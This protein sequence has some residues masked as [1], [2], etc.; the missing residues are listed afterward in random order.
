MYPTRLPTTILLVF[1]AT[2]FFACNNQSKE[3][4]VP[5]TPEQSK[6]VTNNANSSDT[7]NALMANLEQ[8]A[9]TFQV[10]GTKPSVVKGKKG[11][12]IQINPDDL[13][14]KDG[15]APTGEINVTL[16]ELCNQ[17]ELALNNAPTI[18]NGNLLVSGGA[19]YIGLYAN[20]EELR[21]KDGR[22]L[23][24]SF[25]KLSNQKMTLFY[26]ERNSKGELNW[27]DSKKTLMPPKVVADL[28]QLPAEPYEG[29][30][31]GNSNT[32]VNTT[33]KSGKDE[34]DAILDYVD[35]T[36]D[37]DL[38]PINKLSPEAREKYEQYEKTRKIF[39]GT[40]ETINVQQLGWINVDYFL[41]EKNI[42]ELYVQTTSNIK[43]ASI[44]CMFKDIRSV[45]QE[46][47]FL[48]S[49]GKK[50]T[51]FENLPIGYRIKLIA[52]AVANNEPVVYTAEI[53]ITKGQIIN[54]DFKPTNKEEL[55]SV[56]RL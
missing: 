47:F 22:N 56:F 16:K 28:Q 3:K 27:Q 30:T 12:R 33:N 50:I 39:E 4:E 43:A 2:V 24:V 23:P 54:L 26:G 5:T 20:G 32:R 35:T 46:T 29:A 21:L 40:Y 1:L 52:V 19:Y 31:A 49:A 51:S 41:N 17:Q 36:K 34:I 10:S 42:S 8:P 53:K 44:T 45:M 9:Q 48:E 55:K 14:T 15:K 11:T 18:S 6:V 38:K 7:L 25:P 13:E 37:E